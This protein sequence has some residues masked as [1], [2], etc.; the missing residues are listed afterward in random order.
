M[1]HLVELELVTKWSRLALDNLPVGL[2]VI[3][4]LGKIRLFNRVLSGWTGLDGN[5]VLGRRLLEVLGDQKSGFKS[6]FNKLLQTLTTGRE[7]QSLR[8]G[9]VINVACPTACLA[10]TCVLRDK[11]GVSVGAMAVFI[12]SG[13]QQ[14]LEN[15]VIKAEKLAILGQLAAAMV[16]EI[17]NSFTTIGGF[18]QLLRD[19]LKGTPKE[20]YIHIMLA[21]FDNTNRLLKEFLQM[22]R[23]GY[24]NRALFSI[25][26]LITELVMLVESEALM[27]NLNIYV[28][29]AHDTPPIY[30]DCNQLK[31]VLLNI[32]KNAFE[33]LPNNGKLILKTSWDRQE[34]FVLVTICDTG[35]GMD[36]QTLANMFVPFFTTKESGTGLGMF[37]S[38]KII[39]NHGGR[40][41]IQ[42]EPDKGTTVKVLL[43]IG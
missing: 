32:I 12:P 43:P 7:F 18:L 33:A 4:Q 34:G 40:I 35:A 42:S 15:A 24:S 36:E 1:S 21:E 3:D 31:Q 14:E 39:D 41:E 27:H 6:G 20:E 2:L 38:K 5:K 25:T 16:H 23:P 19:D 30:G 13:R 17:R 22:A 37:I 8:P 10:D 28:E 9:T 11:S 29:M 26:K